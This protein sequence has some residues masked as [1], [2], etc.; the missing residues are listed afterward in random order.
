MPVAFIMLEE[1]IEIGDGIF[2][3]GNFSACSYLPWKFSSFSGRD[4]LAFEVSGNLQMRSFVMRCE[5]SAASSA[6]S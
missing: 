1:N 5:F 4:L 3:K 2:K 6:R